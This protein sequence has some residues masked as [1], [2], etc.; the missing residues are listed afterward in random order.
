V[1]LYPLQSAM[2]RGEISPRLHARSSLELYQ[3]SLAKCE[4]FITL[5]HGGIR[6]RGGTMFVAPTKSATLATRLIEFKYSEDQAYCLE[7]GNLYVRVY[8]YGQYITE[9]ASPWKTADINSLQYVQS[10]STMWV[11]HQDYRPQKI[12]R[13]SNSTWLVEQ[14]LFTDGP[15]GSIN[16]DEAQTVYASASTGSITLASSSPIFAPDDVGR[17]FRLEMESYRTIVPWE[18]NGVI[19]KAGGVDA[20]QF[21]RYDGNVYRIVTPLTETWRFGGT[22]PT[23]TK[24]IEQDGP[25]VLDDSYGDIVGVELEY[26]HSGFGVARITEYTNSNTVTA[27]V[28][29]RFPVELVGSDHAA[30]QWSFGAFNVGD[31]PVAVALFEERLCFASQLSV[32]CSKTGDFNTFKTGEKDDDALEFL[33][34]GNEANNIVWL[35]DADGFLAIGTIGGVRALSGS[36]IDE[37]LTPS[38]FKNRASATQRCASMQPM[39]TGQAFL[40]VAGG[41]RSISE[42]VLG[43]GNRFQSTDASQISEHIAK[44]GSGITAIAYQEYPDAMAWSALA[45]GE[46]MGFTY[47]RDQEVRG[48]HRHRLGGN[49]LAHPYGEVV[50]VAVTPGRNGSDD[51]WMIVRRRIN[52]ANTQYIEMMQTAFEYGAAQDVFAVDCGLTYEGSPV[53]NVSGLDYLQ[54]QTVSVLADGRRYDG[55]VV[56]GSSLSQPL[57]VAARRITVGLPFTS[58]ADTLELDAGGRDGSLIGRRKRVLAVVLSLLETDL[59]GLQVS[60]VIKGRW[61]KAKLPSIAVDDGKMKLYTGNITVL[62]DDS[63]EGQARVSIRHTGPGPCT[64]RSIT[65]SFD[66]EP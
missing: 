62:V 46:A 21:C 26:L 43:D 25:M 3:A 18:P 24:G 34:A 38:S 22:P 66:A 5:P 33:L 11:V 15:F 37:S 17:L 63:W 47:Q 56:S 65:P 39:N 14:V 53:T 1:S 35:A 27:S 16:F 8:A 31:F 42:M 51:V 59:S 13:V 57:P 58:T 49:T 12:R 64:I 32:Y 4:N 52:G 7:F 6:K 20:V 45:N 29:S 10:A 44:Q 36:G 19:A 61:E 54:G 41:S 23:H 28:I 55:L 9:F 48:F 2:T 40:Y 30:Y 50:S 60:S